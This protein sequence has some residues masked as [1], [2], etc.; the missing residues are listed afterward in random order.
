MTLERKALINMQQNVKKTDSAILKRID[1]DKARPWNIYKSYWKRF[2]P[3]FGEIQT[4][5]AL[6]LV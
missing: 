4:K 3:I 5:L 1:E 2:S 6:H